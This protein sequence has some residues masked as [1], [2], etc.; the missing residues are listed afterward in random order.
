MLQSFK[1]FKV[2]NSNLE[3]IN[4]LIFKAENSLTLGAASPG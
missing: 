3:Q 1:L 4:W 2:H